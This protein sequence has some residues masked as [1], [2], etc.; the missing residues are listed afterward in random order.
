MFMPLRAAVTARGARTRQRIVAAAADLIYEQGLAATTNEQVRAV[1][2]VS[3]SQLGHYFAD[4]DALVASVFEHQEQLVLDVEMAVWASLDGIAGLRAWRDRIVE[5][6]R[7]VG[8]CRGGCPVGSLA[9]AL[10]ETDDGSRRRVARAIE[11]WQSTIEGGLSR[12]RD[13][14]DLPVDTDVKRLAAAVLASLQGGLLLAQVSR[15]VAPLAAALDVVVD[16]V[17]ALGAAR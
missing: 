11:R 17:E 14:G 15:D 12:L 2:G 8:A 10:A 4:K 7:S 3:G 16:H 9:A 13:S 1:A 5:S 6:H